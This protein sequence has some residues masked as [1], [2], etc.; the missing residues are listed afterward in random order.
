[1]DKSKHKMDIQEKWEALM[2]SIRKAIHILN[3][4]L[5]EA[6]LPEYQNWYVGR[7]MHQRLWALVYTKRGVQLCPKPF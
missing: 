6:D 2:A 7:E 1:M 5:T 4:D 3:I